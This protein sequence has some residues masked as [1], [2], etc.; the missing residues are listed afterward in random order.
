MRLRNGLFQNYEGGA[1]IISFSHSIEPD[2]EAYTQYK[3]QYE[4][5]LRL[6]HPFRDLCYIMKDI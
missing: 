5:F 4:K 1:Q 6:Y 2:N 3:I